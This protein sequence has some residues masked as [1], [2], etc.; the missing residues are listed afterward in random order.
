M[1]CKNATNATG[2]FDVATLGVVTKSPETIRSTT[3]IL[4]GKFIFAEGGKPENAEK[5]PRSQI[6][7]IRAPLDT[8]LV[9]EWA[10]L[11]K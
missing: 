6:L 5:N 3:Q 10:T 7:N 9:A 1:Q 2:L 8:S 11:Y 4:A